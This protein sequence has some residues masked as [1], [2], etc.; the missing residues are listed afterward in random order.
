MKAKNIKMRFTQGVRVIRILLDLFVQTV[1]LANS[2]TA[3]AN[4]TNKPQRPILFGPFRICINPNTFRS[5]K[6]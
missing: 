1:S 4:G 3:S 2:F 5:I 6:V